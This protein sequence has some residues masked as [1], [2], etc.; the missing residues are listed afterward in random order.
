MRMEVR[1]EDRGERLD[2]LLAAACEDHS[3]SRIQTLILGGDVSVNGRTVRPSYR[4]SPGQQVEISLPPVQRLAVDPEDIPLDIFFEDAHLLVV[5]KPPGMV[6]H[7]AGSVR[8]GTLVNALLG[9]CKQL[10]GINGVLRPGIVHRLDKETSGLLVVAKD[11]AAHRGLSKQLECRTVVRKYQAIVWG[12]LPE[13]AGRIEA[14]IGR[15]PANR[16]RQCVRKSGRYAATRYKVVR[17][18]DFLSR[19]E[20]RLETGRTHQVRVHLTHV[21]HP[22]FGDAVYGGGAAR[23]K[24]IDPRFR[25]EAERLLKAGH[26]PMLHAEFL[27]FAH[28]VSGRDLGFRADPPEDMLRVLAELERETGRIG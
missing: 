21:G 3:R 27:K 24:G 8:S 18:Y 16:K 15:D 4:V 17:Y 12:H 7:P 19:L 11:D 1:P 22:V 14:P 13:D 5:D 28:P 6:V 10:S 2:R 25:V 20:V 26:R 23:V 9:C